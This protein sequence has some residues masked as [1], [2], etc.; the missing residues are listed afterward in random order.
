MSSIHPPPDPLQKLRRI[1]SQLEY[2]YEDRPD[3]QSPQLSQWKKAFAAKV[4]ALAHEIHHI[5]DQQPRY[6][7]RLTICALYLHNVRCSEEDGDF[8]FDNL[9]PV[10]HGHPA[11][12]DPAM[13]VGIP[14]D[15]DGTMFP[16]FPRDKIKSNWWM[17]FGM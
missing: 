14:A 3:P 9:R 8:N 5:G 17:T 15:F 10:I 13:K 2:A 1:V 7:P 6:L 4:N 16:L 11:L 12:T